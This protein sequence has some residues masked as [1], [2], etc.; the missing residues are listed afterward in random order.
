MEGR[1]AA[2]WIALTRVGR[3]KEGFMA[4]LILSTDE[5]VSTTRAVRRRLDLTRP[6]EREMIE[7]CITLAQQAPSGF[8]LQLTLESWAWPQRTVSWW[9][10]KRIPRPLAKL[11]PGST[12]IRLAD[13]FHSF[14]ATPP[15]AAARAQLTAGKPSET[16]LRSMF[17]SSSDMYQT[18]QATRPQ[19]Q[20]VR[21]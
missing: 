6:I 5:V 7:E 10:R 1:L 17:A 18:R 13:G 20:S 9:R 12:V 21:R 11:A 3:H 2:C 4:T 8:M 14:Q 15:Q 19:P 16:Y